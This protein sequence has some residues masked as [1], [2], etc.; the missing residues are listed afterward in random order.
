MHALFVVLKKLIHQLL[1]PRS[2]MFCSLHIYSRISYQYQ[3]KCKPNVI[4]SPPPPPKTLWFCPCKTCTHCLFFIKNFKK[5]KKKKQTKC[6]YPPPPPTKIIWF[7]PRQTGTHFLVFIQNLSDQQSA[8]MIK[9]VNQ[10]LGTMQEVES[11]TISQVW[12]I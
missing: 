10:S 8:N 2:Y 1:P 4:T 12:Q 11:S 6:N 5:K 7:L 9:L 3:K